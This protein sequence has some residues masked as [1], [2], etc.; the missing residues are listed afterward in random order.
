MPEFGCQTTICFDV[1][2]AA[3]SHASLMGLLAG[4]AFAVIANLLGPQRSTNPERGIEACVT[5]LV[6]ALLTLT[7][8]AFLYGTTAGEEVLAGR[9]AIMSLLSAITASIAILALFY[10]MAWLAC[11][12]NFSFAA[13]VITR[14][15]ASGVTSVSFM[16]LIIS[17]LNAVAIA[18]KIKVLGTPLFT[19]LAVLSGLM[20][21]I[22]AL[23]QVF[24]NSKW[25][26]GLARSL[27]PHDHPERWFAL[28]SIAAGLVTSLAL[29]VLLQFEP[30]SIIPRQLLYLLMGIALSYE[31]FVI[32]FVRAI[33][34]FEG[35]PTQPGLPITD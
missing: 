13:E 20:I 9:A 7:M 16:Y 26:T 28:A 35:R 23:V 2:V 27:A 8:A 21:C 24:W 32:I 33:P 30:D 15:T 1:R 18:E 5:A 10:A 17:S 22:A 25:F 29:G 4:F 31:L 12:S 14:L 34:A 11:L 6:A 19:V 3:G